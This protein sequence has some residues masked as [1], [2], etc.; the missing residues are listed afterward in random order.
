MPLRWSVRAHD[1]EAIQAIEQTCRV[2][3]VVAQILAVRG[4]TDPLAIN[5]FFD[6]RMTGLR[7]PQSLPGLETAVERIYRAI[8]AKKRI[9]IYGDYDC[10]GMTAT[11]IAFR[12]IET[13]GGCVDYFVPSR[14]ED[15]YGVNQDSLVKLRDR[16]AELI[17][18]VDCGIGSVE[19]IAIA[20]HL[21]MEI[22]VTDHHVIGDRLPEADAIVHP[23]L[24]GGDYPFQGLCGA[25]VAFKLA[26]GLCQ[27]HHGSEKLPAK[28]RD[29][30]FYAVSLAAIGTIA[31]VV[32]LLDENRIIVNH[33][34]KLLRQY[35]NPGLQALVELC[36][37]DG[38]PKLDAEDIAYVLGP[39]L[40]AAGRLGQAQL[41]VEL[42]TVQAA[43]RGKSLADYI[44][45]LNKSR[46]SLDRAMYRAASKILHE[47]FDVARE[48]G[49]VLSHPDWHLGVIG[50]VAGR[51]AEKFHRPTVLISMDR[52][53]TKPAVGSARTA[54][55]VNLYEVLRHCR[56]HLLGFGGH[57][58]AAGLTIEPTNIAAFREAFSH[59]VRCQIPGGEMVPE[60]EIDV[61]APFSQLTVKTLS[62]LEQLAPFGA[63]NPR[64]VM[65]ATGVRLI[66]PPQTIG[67]D[68]RHVAMRLAQYDCRLRAVGFGKGEWLSQLNPADGLFD[69]AFKPVIN[70]FQGRRSVEL[71]LIDFRKSKLA[72][73][74]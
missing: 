12:C 4:L 56:G 55:G 13:L 43:E 19:E 26:W 66:E 51:I 35:A 18:T 11:A 61:Q 38:K 6:L 5:S 42:L 60:L 48:T 10:D 44:D 28:L 49:I 65:C 73:S 59:Q 24:P 52:L 54:C 9:V 36:K 14:I 40:N 23:G 33:G 17:V 32:P 53:G 64:P 45:Q 34:L 29:F 30:L 3:P 47:Q 58:A 39:R 62:E 74:P 63:G 27:R 68:A 16:G 69:F 70:H 57:P 72:A 20:K 22:V 46:E 67:T 25:G 8:E 21:G 71:H 50:I 31:D 2:S 41:G 37:L 7:N 1:I 15:G